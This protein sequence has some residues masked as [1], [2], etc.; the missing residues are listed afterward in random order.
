V[1]PQLDL[2]ADIVPARGLGGFEVGRPV[3]EYQ[4]I[5]RTLPHGKDESS[6]VLPRVHGLWQVVYRMPQLYEPSEEEMDGYYKAMDEFRRR[7][8]AGLDATLDEAVS[9]ITRPPSAPAIDLWVDVRDGVIDAVTAL[10]GYE[11]RF[12][13]LYAGMTYGQARAVEPQIQDVG[14][15]EETPMVGVDGLRLWFD[16]PAPEPMSPEVR[17]KAILQGIVVFDPSRT[18]NGVKPH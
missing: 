3:S 14:F 4:R 17:D 13:E 9:F 11:G 15:M 2:T 7:K 8:R 18:D 1:I 16:E 10:P 5:L 6:G 12:R